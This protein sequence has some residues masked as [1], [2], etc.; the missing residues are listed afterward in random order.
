[1]TSSPDYDLEAR[2]AHIEQA[3]DIINAKLDQLVQPPAQN[4]FPSIRRPRPIFEPAAPATRI[5]RPHREQSATAPEF[6]S[7]QWFTERS[8]DWWVGTLGVLFLVIASFLMYRY[9]VDHRWIT[10]LIR[11]LA[12]F[13][14]GAGMFIAAR[15]FTVLG[16]ASDDRAIGLREILL[17]GGLA[18]WYLA[19]YAAG[20]F[21]HLVSI[22]SARW[23]FLVLSILS[24]WLALKERRITFALVAVVVGFFGQSFFPMT[25]V[26]LGALPFYLAPLAAL[27]V[28]LYLMRGWKSILWLTFIGFWYDSLPLAFE[29]SRGTA[30]IIG[31]A[32]MAIAFAAACVRAPLLRW[33]LVL[34]N[35]DRYGTSAS[36]APSGLWAIVILSPMLALGFV[37]LSW[38]YDIKAVWGII[39]LG[40]AA[41]AYLLSRERMESE[42]DVAHLAL[43]CAVVWSFAGVEWIVLDF[44]QRS[45]EVN[46]ILTATAAVYTII[47]IR[48]LRGMDLRVPRALMKISAVLLLLAVVIAEIV[49]LDPS[50]KAVLGWSW[51]AAEALVIVMAIRLLA[52]MRIKAS[53][54]P[55]QIAIVVVAYAAVMLVL[56][57]VLGS[58]WLP[59]VTTSYAMLGVTM[60]VLSQRFDEHKLLLR[61]GAVTMVI[62]VGRLIFIDMSSV[63][64]I[65]RVLLFLG[66]GATF[67]GV[68]HRLR[69]A[70]TISQAGI[71]GG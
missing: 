48:V 22:Q 44:A 66:C 63:E 42:K 6:P 4:P 29:R 19:S 30:L 55:E 36:I 51:T 54:F 17:G 60:I 13:A 34:A 35:P 65:W 15:Q 47:L 49:T 31:A 41:A 43:T 53:D 21:Y 50:S 24:G 18:V 37:S 67:V 28:V 12:G 33:R 61:F 7:I 3:L 1:M 9:A 71:P 10:P 68:S 69:S 8:A 45:H 46:S 23:L 52:S 62:V 26:R 27:G 5:A 59:L 39:E 38:P 2:V 70:P 11:V 40:L 20:V 56:S 14:V 57:R 58:I 64:T 16:S 32:L 25:L